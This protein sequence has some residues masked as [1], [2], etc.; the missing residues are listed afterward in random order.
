VKNLPDG[1]VEI[2]CEGAEEVIKEFLTKMG[3]IFKT[4]IRNADIEWGKADGGFEGFDI[5][6]E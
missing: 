1:R 5:R 2:V 6:F 3:A 4:Y